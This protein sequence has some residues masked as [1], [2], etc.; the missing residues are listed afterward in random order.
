[1]RPNG[2][3]KSQKRQKWR[4]TPSCGCSTAKYGRTYHTHSSDHLRLFPKTIRGSEKWKL[5]YQRRKSMERSNKRE[6]IDY[7][8]ESGRHRSTQMW[9]MRIYGIMMC[10]HMD[11]WYLH[12]QVEWS[13]V[14][15]TL[16]SHLSS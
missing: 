5:I 16:S 6:K 12:Q 9:I 10:Q 11:A 3:D 13:E 7:K 4:C 14:R 8:L 2:Y 1:M 15:K